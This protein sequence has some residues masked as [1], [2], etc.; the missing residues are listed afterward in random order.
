MAVSQETF[1]DIT[2]PED[3]E[4][5]VRADGKVVWISVDGVT[6]LRAC[7]IKTLRITDNREAKST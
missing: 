2:A 1:Q 5:E 4:I 6:V 3:L 7:R